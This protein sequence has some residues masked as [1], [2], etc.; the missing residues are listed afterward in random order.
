V[1]L[2]MREQALDVVSSNTKSGDRIDAVQS[3]T[4]ASDDSPHTGRPGTLGI[5]RPISA[6]SLP[7]STAWS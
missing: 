4:K 7:G 3:N 6:R 2:M 1:L 5:G